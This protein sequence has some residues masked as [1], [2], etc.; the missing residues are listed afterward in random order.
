MGTDIGYW[1]L[2]LGSYRSRTT[3]Y[4]KTMDLYWLLKTL[5]GKVLVERNEAHWEIFL[6]L[7]EMQLQLQYIDRKLDTLSNPNVDAT[8]PSQENPQAMEPPPEVPPGPYL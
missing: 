3:L 8:R 1:I 4:T 5:M 7:D 2:D 6:Q